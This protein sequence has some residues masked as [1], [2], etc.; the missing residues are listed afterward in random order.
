MLE[1]VTWRHNIYSKF[2]S[3]Y[4]F[5]RPKSSKADSTNSVLCP[6]PCFSL[7]IRCLGPTE[8][9]QVQSYAAQVIEIHSFISVRSR[10]SHS[11][12]EA[13]LALWSMATR[14]ANE[15]VKTV[16]LAAL[17]QVCYRSPQQAVSILEKVGLPKILDF[18]LN[19]PHKAKGWKTC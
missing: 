14:A 5:A 6:P 3:L 9:I 11:G 8:E 4:P 18:I 12:V 15:N 17:A 2:P 7:V 10:F 13:G 1:H 16:A 19:A